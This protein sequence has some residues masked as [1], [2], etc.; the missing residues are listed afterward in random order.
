MLPE[1]G[2][3]ACAVPVYVCV[4]RWNPGPH[5]HSCGPGAAPAARRMGSSGARGQHDAGINEA[6]TCRAITTI[7][8]RNSPGR[9]PRRLRAASPARLPPVRGL[10]IGPPLPRRRLFVFCARAGLEKLASMRRRRFRV[11]YFLRVII[12]MPRARLTVRA[13]RA[14]RAS[15]RSD[16]SNAGRGKNRIVNEP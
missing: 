9:C 16:L 13:R 14:V 10:S 4:A 8:S 7:P 12:L 15:A 1:I 2:P 5:L 6:P 3:S 11:P